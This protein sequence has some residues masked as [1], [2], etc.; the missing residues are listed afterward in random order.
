[1]PADRTSTHSQNIANPLSSRACHRKQR[2][3]QM[4]SEQQVEDNHAIRV[5][6]NAKVDLAVGT[7]L[8]W[9]LDGLSWSS[10]K[11][12]VRKRSLSLVDVTNGETIRVS[13]VG[14]KEEKMRLP[15]PLPLPLPVHN[16]DAITPPLDAVTPAIHA[17]SS[18]DAGTVRLPDALQKRLQAQ[19]EKSVKRSPVKAVFATL[20][21]EGLPPRPRYEGGMEL[22]RIG[23]KRVEVEVVEEK[24]EE[25]EEEETPRM[26]R[27][28]APSPPPT[29]KTLFPTTEDLDVDA[30]AT[31][32]LPDAKRK[33]PSRPS[34]PAAF[35]S[36][37]PGPVSVGAARMRRTS[38]SI[39]TQ[40]VAPPAPLMARRGRAQTL[41]GGILAGSKPPTSL[42]A[43]MARAAEGSAI[44][45][46]PT[47]G[48]GAVMGLAGVAGKRKRE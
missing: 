10:E 25:E 26:F 39:T 23:S 21:R 45:R 11:E 29:K 22:A 5:I 43:A 42:A 41:A 32:R 3:A 20:D 34:A 15:L 28:P 31:I 9:D 14:G 40:P 7:G 48:V 8:G 12:K 35:A 36:V 18:T 17:R 44:Q 33:R 16:T 24:E 47:P 19:V 37:V 30:E 6:M 1:M 4:E 2:I 13:K 46:K 27:R 38:T